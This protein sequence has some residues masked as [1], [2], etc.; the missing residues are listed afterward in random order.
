MV[1]NHD[2]NNQHFIFFCGNHPKCYNT[3]LNTVKYHANSLKKKFLN[4]NLSVFWCRFLIVIFGSQ[5]LSFKHPLY[6]NLSNNNHSIDLWTVKIF[7]LALWIFCA[8][9]DFLSHKN[10]P[11]T[12]YI[13]KVSHCNKVIMENYEKNKKIPESNF[14]KWFRALKMNRNHRNKRC[15]IRMNTIAECETKMKSFDT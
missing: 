15:A 5:F 1:Y 8:T 10:Q 9:F 12:N 13:V 7:V 14:G 6:T 2:M 4:V 11:Q 3:T